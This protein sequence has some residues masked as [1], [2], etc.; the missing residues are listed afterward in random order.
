MSQVVGLADGARR[1]GGGGAGGDRPRAAPLPRPRG[2]SRR[3]SCPRSSCPT[4]CSAP[5]CTSTWRAS[6]GRPRRSRL[7]VGHI[8]IATPYVI[9][10]VTAGLVGMDPRLEEAAM[11]LGAS[12]VQAFVKV[13]L[14]LLRSSLVT[15]AVF[16][17]IISFSDINLALFLAGPERAQPARAHLLADPVRGRPVDRRRLGAADRHR[18]GAHPAR[19]A[20][21]PPPADGVAARPRGR[22]STS[23]GPLDADGRFSSMASPT[24]STARGDFDW[25]AKRFPPMHAERRAARRGPAGA[26]DDRAGDCERWH[27]RVGGDA[28]GLAG[29]HA[30]SW[31]SPRDGRWRTRAVPANEPLPL[32]WRAP[33]RLGPRG[34]PRREDQSVDLSVTHRVRAGPAGIPAPE[35][36]LARCAIAVENQHCSPRW[37]GLE[38]ADV[39]VGGLGAEGRRIPHAAEIGGCESSA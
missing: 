21:V 37:P 8:V 32:A 1:H 22:R 31:R 36:R 26:R 3:S 12:R 18:R 19:A 14:P 4:S 10:C 29:Y 7:L 27:R 5:P 2:R 6:P 38:I 34:L 11:S 16:A 17:F 30:A 24:A 23:F 13:T 33:A 20:A 35:A 15:G 25:K 9:R 28:I 39:E